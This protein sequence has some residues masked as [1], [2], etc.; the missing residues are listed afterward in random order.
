MKCTN[1]FLCIFLSA[2]LCLA[3]GCGKN[4]VALEQPY[5]VYQT[6]GNIGISTSLEAGNKTFFADGLCVAED[7]M[8]GT[9]TTHSEVAEGAG[10]FNLATGAVVYSKNIYQKMYPASTTKILTAYIALKYCDDLD[11]YVTISE[12]AAN[13]SADSSVCHLN[14][15]DVI[16][17]RDLL[18][19]MML[20]SGNDAAIAIAEYV[21][22]DVESFAT[23]MNQEA[24]SLGA[25][26]SHFVNPN[27]LPDPM[28][29]T[30]V[31][32]LYLIM[33]AAVQNQTFL[34]II[35]TE[36]YDAVYTDANG[37]AV[38][39]TWNNTSK[40]ITGEVEVPDGFTVVGGKTGTTGEAGYCLVLYSY[41]ASAQ[42]IIS[43]VLKSDGRSNLYLLMN[44]MLEGFAN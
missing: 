37:E 31:Y 18:Y 44:E 28:H 27:G 10:A 22:G 20:R 9:D 43:I 41:N 34:D 42:P 3:T 29:Y 4:S 19:G 15:G 39:K 13:Q 14:A 6:T 40:Y 2:F 21:S 7:I 23:L 36:S 16:S 30:S 26:Q 12:N 35:S 38:E 24:Q 11:A 5:D 33:E 17:L 8:L 32:D 1:K 25:T